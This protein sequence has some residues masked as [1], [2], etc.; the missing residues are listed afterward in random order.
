MQTPPPTPEPKT[1]AT[2]SGQLNEVSSRL[3]TAVTRFKS[4]FG[5]K[6]DRRRV[7]GRPEVNGQAAKAP[8]RDHELNEVEPH[9]SKHHHTP[10]RCPAKTLISETEVDGSSHLPPRL[11]AGLMELTVRLGTIEKRYFVDAAECP[12]STILVSSEADFELM[13]GR[14]RWRPRL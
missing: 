9:S 2:T 1:H 7:E 3:K 12:I 8:R 4:L 13:A 10:H 14:L 11:M 6:K 5:G